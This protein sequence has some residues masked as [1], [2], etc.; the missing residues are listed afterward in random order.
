VSKKQIRE[1]II[2]P[3]DS[4]HKFISGSEKAI[5]IEIQRLD[6]ELSVRII[7]EE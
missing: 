1:Q 6:R 5:F 3:F 4:E 2:T 7:N